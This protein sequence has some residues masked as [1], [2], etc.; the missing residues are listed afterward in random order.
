MG[1]NAN[2]EI[3]VTLDHPNMMNVIHLSEVAA[4]TDPYDLCGLLNSVYC[5]DVP[6][7][8]IDYKSELKMDFE[9]YDSKW[10][11]WK[12]HCVILI[13]EMENLTIKVHGT[14]DEGE[15]W[16]ALFRSGEDPIHITRSEWEWDKALEYEA[17]KMKEVLTKE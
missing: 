5:W 15:E 16:A 14:D 3:E 11:K 10:Y 4:Q 17:L 7:S 6:L 9:I 8:E 12:E 2:W 1:Y 13:N